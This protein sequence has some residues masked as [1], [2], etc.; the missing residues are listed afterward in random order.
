MEALEFRRKSFM[1]DEGLIDRKEKKK[2]IS[3]QSA[4]DSMPLLVKL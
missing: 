1:P 3:E 4:Q 2:K